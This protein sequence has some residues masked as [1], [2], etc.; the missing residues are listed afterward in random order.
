MNNLGNSYRITIKNTNNNNS[1]SRNSNNI[2]RK[3]ESFDVRTS[4]PSILNKKTSESS[5]NDILA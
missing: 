5:V 2:H 3:L 1:S 4:K